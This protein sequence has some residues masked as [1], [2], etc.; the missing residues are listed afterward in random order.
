[1]RSSINC[2]YMR[3]IFSIISNAKTNERGNLLYICYLNSER[4]TYVASTH[5]LIYRLMQEVYYMKKRALSAPDDEAAPAS[6]SHIYIRVDITW[7]RSLRSDQSDRCR[8]G[9]RNNKKGGIQFTG[10]P[11]LTRISRAERRSRARS[12]LD[13]LSQTR[14]SRSS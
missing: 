2:L 14:D 9:I 4:Y 3:R 1:M 6:V 12:R 13:S 5:G 7:K 10:C 11:E 8:T